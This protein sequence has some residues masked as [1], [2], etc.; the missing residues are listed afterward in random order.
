MEVCIHV[1][2]IFSC[3]W[4]TTNGTA[5]VAQW[6]FAIRQFLFLYRIHSTY[7]NVQFIQMW[8]KI[9]L[10]WNNRIDS[11]RWNRNFWTQRILNLNKII[12]K[13][14]RLIMSQPCAERTQPTFSHFPMLFGIRPANNIINL[15]PVE[16]RRAGKSIP[17]WFPRVKGGWMVFAYV[18]SRSARLKGVEFEMA[19]PNKNLLD[20][21]Y[22]VWYV[23]HKN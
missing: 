10:R 16:I 19:V 2:S 5:A 17:C 22:A 6:I 9:N 8:L 4:K 15:I 20:F 12:I 13:V 14:N 11:V 1:R 18:I 23:H 7:F 21:V 3:K